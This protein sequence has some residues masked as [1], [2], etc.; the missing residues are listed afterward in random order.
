M[1]EYY[2]ATRKKEVLPFATTWMDLKSIMLSEI[3]QRKIN[4][5][6]TFI[7]LTTLFFPAS[8]DPLSLFLPPVP[9]LTYNGMTMSPP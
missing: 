5:Y 6:I 7:L 2:S 3:S 9:S 8:P 1:I 4:T